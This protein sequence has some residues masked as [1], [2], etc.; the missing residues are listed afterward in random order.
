MSNMIQIICGW[1]EGVEE[2]DE[3]KIKGRGLLF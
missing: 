2:K 1:G 3:I